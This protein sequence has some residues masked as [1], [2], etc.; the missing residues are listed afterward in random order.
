MEKDLIKNDNAANI[1][2]VRISDETKALL[3]CRA[4]LGDI[5]NTVGNVV[6][7]TYR[8]DIEDEFKGFEDAF[9]MFDGK[10]TEIISSYIDRKLIDNNF[11]MM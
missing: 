9:W 2:N 7:K 8:C 10:L 3:L 5:Y 1:G 6:E 4:R 11:K